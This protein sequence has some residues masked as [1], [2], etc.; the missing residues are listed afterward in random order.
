MLECSSELVN[1]VVEGGD[2]GLETLS[3]SDLLNKFPNSAIL[4]EG[5][6]LEFF[7]MVEHAL[8]ECTA[9]GSCSEGLGESE[10]LSDGQMSLELDEWGSG[11]GLFTND[12]TSSGGE[13]RVD[14]TNCI[15]RALNFN[16]EN[17]FLES[18]GCSQLGGVEDTA[19]SWDDLTTTSVDSIGVEGDVVDVESDSTHVLFGHNTFFGCPLEGSLSG[20]LDF[21][22]VLDSFSYITKHVGASGLWSEAPNLLGFVDIPFVVVGEHSVANLG[23]LL[24]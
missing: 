19:G 6:S 22:Q 24:G 2:A 21:V 11:N 8:W 13:A 5:I 15:I 9:R 18:W 14:A 1:E 12:Y 7:P 3:L 23:V 17:W 10:G 20:V 4:F 16:K